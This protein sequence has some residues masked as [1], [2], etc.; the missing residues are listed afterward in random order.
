MAHWILL[1]AANPL[2]NIADEILYFAAV[3][4]AHAIGYNEQK[5]F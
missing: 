2:C 4:S 1:T 3:L 5:S